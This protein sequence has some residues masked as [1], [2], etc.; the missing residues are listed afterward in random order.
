MKN[1]LML[2]LMFLSF[3]VTGCDPPT[4]ADSRYRKEEAGEEFDTVNDPTS[5]QQAPPTAGL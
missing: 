4:Q 1:V 3:V 2:C 5:N